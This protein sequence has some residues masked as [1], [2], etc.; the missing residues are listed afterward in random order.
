MLGLCGR[1]G[2]LLLEITHCDVT[3]HIYTKEWEQVLILALLCHTLWGVLTHDW[4]ALIRT[5]MLCD[6]VKWREMMEGG[7]GGVCREMPGCTGCII[8]PAL[9]LQPYM[10]SIWKPS[11]YK[12]THTEAEAHYMEHKKHTSVLCRPVKASVFLLMLLLLH[13]FACIIIREIWRLRRRG[14]VEE[15]G[16][17][18]EGQWE[19]GKVDE[20]SF[21]NLSHLWLH[22]F[23]KVRA[24]WLQ[25]ECRLL[26]IYL[27]IYLSTL[28]SR[29]GEGQQI[30]VK[31]W[32]IPV[33]LSL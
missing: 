26:L 6:R 14:H 20:S 8:P 4:S 10:G 25:T 24:S 21:R 32:F 9:C 1:Q 11:H 7:G 15:G 2:L 28:Q 17:A 12:D 3:Q 33:G 30:R 19:G 5:S 27:F 16:W 29:F 22:L 31:F 23:V 13:T 18:D